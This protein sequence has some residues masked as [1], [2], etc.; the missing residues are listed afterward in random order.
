MQKQEALRRGRARA[1]ELTGLALG[2]P[3][4]KR[5]EAAGVLSPSG[6]GGGGCPGLALQPQ[7]WAGGPRASG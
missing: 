1:W 2:P 6:E 4:P 3:L 5:H 7:R